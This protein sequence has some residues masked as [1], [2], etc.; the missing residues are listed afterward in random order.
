MYPQEELEWDPTTET[1]FTGGMPRKTILNPAAAE[2]NPGK[3]VSP[4]QAT[5]PQTGDD[6]DVKEKVETEEEQPLE[7]KPQRVQ[8][9]PQ[10]NGQIDSRQSEKPM[11]TQRERPMDTPGSVPVALPEQTV[12]QNRLQNGD[13][14]EP[15]EDVDLD[16]SAES[17]DRFIQAHTL[18]LDVDAAGNVSLT[19]SSEI[20][21][22]SS[23]DSFM[24]TP[25]GHV[26]VPDWSS[27]MEGVF[28]PKEDKVTSDQ[29]LFPDIGDS[30][31]SKLPR[32]E[33]DVSLN[34]S[35]SGSDVAETL[36]AELDEE[37]KERTSSTPD[38]IQDQESSKPAQHEEPEEQRKEK[39]ENENSTLSVKADSAAVSKDGDQQTQEQQ[40]EEGY[41]EGE[42]YYEEEEDQEYEDEEEYE[43]DEGEEYGPEDE[44]EGYE[45]QDD[46]DGYYYYD[47]G[48]AKP[49]GE[50]SEYPVETPSEDTEFDATKSMSDGQE[51][52][53]SAPNP[54]I[55]KLKE[56]EAHSPGATL[57]PEYSAAASSLSKT[58][59][60]PPPQQTSVDDASQAPDNT[61]G[62]I[63]IMIFRG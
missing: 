11:D 34:I 27:A 62:K 24:K 20:Q 33:S 29:D 52:V 4:T 26:H 32:D 50:K 8:Q 5:A 53:S 23:Q 55:S 17:L 2:F 21:S 57:D 31:G 7:P 10:Q 59:P 28:S 42:E 51:N 6:W 37:Q 48:G 56:S 60:D 43:E 13:Y 45:E 1:E 41:E 30:P 9:R 44:E 61:E 18:K 22:Q 35:C 40:E 19:P 12:T 49:L 46:Y 25:T 15:I 16:D 39:N 63:G 47:D 58:S 3:T 54:D 14:P 36:T 38:N